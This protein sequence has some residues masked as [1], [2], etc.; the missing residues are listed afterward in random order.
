MSGPLQLF[1]S[2]SAFVRL[3]LQLF[4]VLLTLAHTACQRSPQF[5]KEEEFGRSDSAGFPNRGASSVARFE[6]MG[7]PKKRVM[8]LNFWN[9][10]PVQQND[11]GTFAASELKRGLVL[12]QRVIVPED[13]K[14]DLGTVNFVQG[15]R[16]KVAQLM[17][18][19]RRLG[20][21]VLVIGR[22]SKIVFRQKGD[23]VGIFQQKQSLA[24]VELEAKLFDV[25]GGR[26]IMSTA[27]SGEATSNNV[28][29]MESSNLES[30]A[31]R[32]ELIRYAGRE[33]VARFVPEVMK[34]IEK[35]TWQGR[36]ARILGKKFYINA[37]RTSGL[38]TGDILRVMSP[39]DDIYDPVTGAF[40]GRSQGPLKGTLEVV[41][42]MGTDG[43]VAEIHTGAN[44]KEGDV[45]QLY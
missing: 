2:R 7:Q 19:G 1:Q 9:D 39:G 18:E 30:P 42:Y 10:T 22:V 8:I 23:D 4:L 44:F 41:D 27:Q 36:I 17:R 16:V 13:V 33:A 25:Q 45:I 28:V 34:A 26:E 20:V 35:M 15:D 38:I 31:Y 37:G 24:A 14:T 6:A 21:A 11:I 40:L 32:A 43:A 12:T 5:R 3:H 29:T